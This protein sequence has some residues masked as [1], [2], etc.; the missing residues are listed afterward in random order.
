MKKK[1][2]LKIAAKIGLGF[3]ILTLAL[4]LNAVLISRVITESGDLN[5]KISEIYEPSD[6][7]LVKLYNLVSN[8][9]ML[10]RNWVF[11][12]KIA[13]TPDKRKLIELQSKDFPA[14]RKEIALISDEWDENSRRNFSQISAL[15]KD[16][17][18]LMQQSIM[19]QLNSIEKYDDPGV[20]FMVTPSVAED[21]E[22]TLLSN[23]TLQLL[24]N[25][26]VHQKNAV[27]NARLQMETSFS[28]LKRYIF[29][30]SAILILAS[31][32]LGFITVRSLVVPINN[33]KNRLLSMS[34]GILPEKKMKERNDEIGQMA[35]ALNEL[36][37]GL[38]A[39]S[40]FALEIGRGNYQSN[41]TPLSEND[42]LGNSLL[43]MRDD[44]NAATIEESKRKEEDQQ[45][46]WATVGIAKFSEILR[47]DND[48]LDLLSYHVISNLVKYMEANQGGIFLVN[49][50]DDTKPFAELVSC[51]AFNRK[52]HLEKR[53]EIGEGLVGRCIL[54]KATIFL[55]DIPDGYIKITSGMGESNPRNL[56]LVPLMMN[57]EVFGVIEIASFI[58]F[59]K[60]RIEFVEK[61]A[62]SIASTLKAVKINTRTSKLLE[63]SKI[64]AEELAAQE[65]EMRQNMEEL[66]ATQ[67]QSF[68]KEKEL[69]ST[70][71]ELR[72]KIGDR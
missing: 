40:G 38:K 9:H 4:I 20:M 54:E 55:S 58:P 18:F 44:L 15:I 50:T 46:N 37:A 29:I 72:K 21:G 45:R 10:L 71:E 42:V 47:Q 6:A 12:D 69:Q 66:R 14:L 30:T 35:K 31:L 60:Y 53:V 68:R 63:Q 51:Y 34:Q 59:E 17:L 23:K 28:S 8:S 1:I 36:V 61:I 22:V 70:V 56:V 16:T 41:F 25:L 39:I 19:N 3:G 11:V 24:D 33:I 48:K 7:K 13:D 49:D 27:Q 5:R 65:E 26:I 67:E 2:T 64:Q 62:E 43:R 52:K 32:F 57:D